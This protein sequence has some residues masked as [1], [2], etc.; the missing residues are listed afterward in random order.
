VRRLERGALLGA[1]GLGGVIVARHGLGHHRAQL[2]R[3]VRGRAARGLARGPRGVIL[4]QVHGDEGGAAV[5][6]LLEAA[7]GGHAR[8]LVVHDDV[9]ELVA[10]RGLDRDLEL[11]RRHQHVGHQAVEA[12][13]QLAVFLSL[14]HHG[15]HALLAALVV[16]LD[17]LQRGAAR[18]LVH[19]RAA[20][21]EGLRLDL[22][23]LG[24]QAIQA[25]L[26]LGQGL[27]DRLALGALGHQATGGLV[28]LG[29][30]AG[31]G[32]L[33]LLGL[34]ALAPQARLEV[35]VAAEE[36][37][38]VVLLLAGAR[39][40]LEH[41]VLHSV[42]VRLA[43]L[44]LEQRRVELD[45]LRAQDIALLAARR[46]QLF[47][48]RLRAVSSSRSARSLLELH[49]EQLRLLAT[50]PPRGAPAARRCSTARGA[51]RCWSATARPCSTSARTRPLRRHIGG[52]PAP[53]RRTARPSA[54]SAAQALLLRSSASASFA[55][56]CLADALGLQLAAKR[57]I[58][59]SSKCRAAPPRSRSR[60]RAARPSARL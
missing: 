3:H 38:D 24:L 48:G 46:G 41:G 53:W 29:A 7:D 57:S 28:G 50:R 58:A 2:G 10:Q 52:A 30:V 44:D 42:G 37:G 14:P 22:H 6:G 27:V 54:A 26:H 23:E 39:G 60:A 4:A 31:G 12:L 11:R 34:G 36:V 15:A 20:Q 33:D 51:P 47:A 19:Q 55:P 9:L 35:G 45:L 17:L 13:G 16:L 5:G 40:H 8:V 49:L 18:A 1:R 21:A 43:R 32:L 56:I 25:A 59:S